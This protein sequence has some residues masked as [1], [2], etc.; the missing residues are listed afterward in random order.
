MKFTR[1]LL[2]AALFALS[3]NCA[4]KKHEIILFGMLHASHTG[5]AFINEL[6]QTEDL[7]TY[8]FRNFYNGAGVGI[9][10]VNN[11]GLADIYF[12]GNTTPN[13]LYLNKGNFVFEDITMQGGVACEG[14]WSTGV[15][16]ADINGDG[17]LDIYVCKSGKDEGENR[18]NELFINHGDLTFSEQSHKYGLD[19]KGLSVHATFFDYDLDGDLDCYLLNNSFHSVSNFEPLPGLRETSDAGLNNILLRN[20]DGVFMNVTSHSGIY[21][22]AISFGLGATVSDINRDGWP[23][24]YVSNDFFERDYLYL[25]NR[26]GTFR[27]CLEDY[28]QET[29]MGAMGADIADINNDGFVEIYVTEMTSA[30]NNRRK[31]KTVYQNWEVYQSAVKNGYHHQFARNTLQLNNKNGAFSEIGRYAGVDRTDWS[32]G[33]LIFDMDADGWND[34]FVANG[35]YKDLLDRDYL[36]FYS[37]PRNVRNVF[38]QAEHGVIALIDKM[39]SEKISNYALINNKNLT[40]TNLSK[41]LGLSDPG[42]SNGAAYGDLNN[43]GYPDLVINNINMPPFIFQNN[44]G[45]LHAN[46]YISIELIGNT[47]NTGAIGSKINVYAGGFELLREKFPNRGFMS[48]VDPVIHVGLGEISRI[49][50]LVITW[51]DLSKTTLF[52][53]EYNQRL[54]IDQN[55][56]KAEPDKAVKQPQKS[57]FINVEH[58]MPEVIHTENTFSD[59]DRYKLLFHMRSNE[60]PKIGV[61]DVNADGLDDFYL[62]GAKDSPGALYLQTRNGFVRSNENLFLQDRLSEETDC[63]FFDADEDGDP[64]LYIATGSLE[65]PSSSSALADRLYFNDGRGNFTKSPQILPSFRFESTSCVRAADADNDG[66]LDLFVGV[67]MMPFSY[68]INPDSYLLINDGKGNFSDKT[69]VLAADLR[70]FGHVT[71]ATWSDIDGD[72]DQDLVIV[73]EWMP[74][75]ILKNEKGNFSVIRPPGLQHSS[76]WWRTLQASDVDGDGDIDFIAGNN[77]LNSIFKAS[78]HHPV[79]MYVND[80]DLSGSIDHLI[81]TYEDE[82]LYPVAMM[83]DLINQ[84]PSLANKIGTFEKYG[85][86]SIDSLFSETILGKSVVQKAHM[87]ESCVILNDGNDTFSMMPLPPEAQFF[88]VYSILVEDWDAD[89]IVDLII[90]GNQKRVKPEVGTYNAGHGLYLRGAGNGTFEALNSNTSGIVIHGEIRDLKTLTVNGE[91]IILI[92][93]NNAKTE[94]IKLNQK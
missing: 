14:V 85:T 35:I 1:H 76:G 60:G 2:L 69:R 53:V 68:G 94:Y 19:I 24:I 36:E 77:G 48:S 89:G 52:D 70:S 17:W 80:F 86:Y 71:D 15:S 92:A 57:I 39:P 13:K 44:T 37:N 5:I 32:W 54:T 10:D 79:E 41:E 83:H 59:F 40:F 43:D 93:K 66:D 18:H 9:G 90:G 75:T 4:N 30:F 81:C 31:S 23:D 29:S 6:D 62:C 27:E 78:I 7:N 16:F 28:I 3:Q 87:M 73:G 46:N 67:R 64:D 33:A 55:Q 65:F 91:Q 74:I 72:G 21:N 11:D 20:D 34:I 51:P 63:L 49:D 22:T 61:A 88:P 45:L 12:C 42:F 56:S 26:D 47:S 38:E 82:T 84:I 8:T 58:D 50:S 25:N